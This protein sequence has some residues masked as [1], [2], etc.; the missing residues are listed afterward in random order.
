MLKTIEGVVISET[1]YGESSKILNILTDEG[2]IGVMSKGCKSVKSPLRNV[3]NKLTYASYTIYYNED[4]LS[5]LKEG[6]II[7]DFYH[8]KT[9]LELISY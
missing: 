9:D 3:S 7:N 2:V 1:A 6:K 5:T 4:K 8:I